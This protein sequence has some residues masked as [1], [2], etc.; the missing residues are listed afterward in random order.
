MTIYD[1]LDKYAAQQ[2]WDDYSKLEIALS[3]VAYREGTNLTVWENHLRQQVQQE[4]PTFCSKAEDGKHVKAEG[5]PTCT[6]CDSEI[7]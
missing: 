7:D 3:F 2:G 1:M 4:D 6:L 5:S